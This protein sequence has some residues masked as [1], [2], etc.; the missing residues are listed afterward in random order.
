MRIN[1]KE[2]L[3]PV[4]DEQGEII[5]TAPRSL[6]HNGKSRLLHPVVHLHLF[7]SAGE[8]FLQ[9]RS[10]T[11][12]TYPGKWDTSVGGHISLGETTSEALQREAHEELG[13]KNL[14]SKFL[15]TYVWESPHER[16]LVHSFLTYTD[17]L[18]VIDKDEIEEG[19]FWSA[20]EIKNNMGK[21]VF[22]PNFEHEFNKLIESHI[23]ETTF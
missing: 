14:N 12:D 1:G 10:V 22:T 20:G 16:E 19:K 23:L 2:E 3:F 13:L 7:N 18:P 15:Y 6:C 21:N 17:E 11:K 5:G 4:V 8:L 9:K